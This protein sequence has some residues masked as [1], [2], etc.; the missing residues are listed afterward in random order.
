VRLGA[1]GGLLLSAAGRPVPAPLRCAAVR[2]GKQGG[3]G[4]RL[5]LLVPCAAERWGRKRLPAGLGSTAGGRWLGF[6]FGG[7]GHGRI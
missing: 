7:G 3:C 1:Q 5:C 6:G 2:L 4:L